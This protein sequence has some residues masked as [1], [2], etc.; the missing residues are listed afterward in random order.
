MTRHYGFP[1]LAAG[2]LVLSACLTNNSAY[3][4][5]APGLSAQADTNAPVNQRRLAGVVE[6]DNEGLDS[7]PAKR[8]ADAYKKM[9]DLVA[10]V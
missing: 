7:Q 6:Y 5:Q 9:T 3:L 1:L 2:F 8:R 10:R 4:A